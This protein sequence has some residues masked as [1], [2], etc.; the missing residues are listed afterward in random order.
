MADKL[1]VDIEQAAADWACARGWESIKFT[2]RGSRGWPDR[3]FISISGVH[4]WI[5][6]KKNGKEPRKVQ[7]YR[8]KQLR[9]RAVNAFWIDNLEEAQTTLK[10]YED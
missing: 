4:V 8:I 6:F 3:I 2:P 7:L 1:E 10:F 9:K 5:E